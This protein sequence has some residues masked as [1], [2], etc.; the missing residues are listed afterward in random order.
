MPHLDLIA[1]LDGSLKIIFGYRFLDSIGHCKG[2]PCTG[3]TRLLLVLCMLQASENIS[4]R[5]ANASCKL[6]VLEKGFVLP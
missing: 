2:E 4:V 3:P 5:L 1:N 6:Q